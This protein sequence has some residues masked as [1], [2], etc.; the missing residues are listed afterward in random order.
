MK[1]AKGLK[2]VH[3][4]QVVADVST[5]CGCIGAHLDK[6]SGACRLDARITEIKP[7]SEMDALLNRLGELLDAE[8]PN[9]LKATTIDKN[10]ALV[11]SI[12]VSAGSAKGGPHKQIARLK[13]VLEGAGFEGLLIGSIIISKKKKLKIR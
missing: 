11:T 1:E 7:T 10:D 13:E 9:S 12:L 6:R 5:A 4:D 8:F 3:G 2:I